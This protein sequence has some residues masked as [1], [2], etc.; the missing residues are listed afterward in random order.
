M[1][2]FLMYFLQLIKMSYFQ[3]RFKNGK[4]LSAHKLGAVAHHDD[5]DSTPNTNLMIV[6]ADSEKDA[7]TI[8]DLKLKMY[9]TDFLICNDRMVEL[10]YQS[11]R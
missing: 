4:S 6:E 5:T 11:G 9:G 8:A 7:Q 1:A 10:Q 3:V 2:W